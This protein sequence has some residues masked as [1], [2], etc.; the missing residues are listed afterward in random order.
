MVPLPRTC[1]RLNIKGFCFYK[2]T[3]GIKRHLA[4]YPLGFP[5]FTHW[6]SAN[7]AD[8]VGLIEPL[9]LN[10]AYCQAKPVALPKTT[11]LLQL[12]TKPSKQEKA[13]PG[14]AVLV[15]AAVRCVIE[16]SHA[17][18][19]RCKSRV[20]NFER[21]HAPAMT[22]LKVCFVRPMLKRPAAPS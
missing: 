21:T 13:A 15:P 19:E 11:I 3:N 9:T 14:Q 4:V 22:K 6:T 5:C 8:D 7:V 16:R 20:K 17:R 1:Q 10:I 18:R 12:S 2:A